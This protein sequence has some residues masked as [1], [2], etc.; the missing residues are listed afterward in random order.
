MARPLSPRPTDGGCPYPHRRP[1]SSGGIEE[2]EGK[3]PP[4]P[5]GRVTWQ[6]LRVR[7]WEQA[8]SLN[9]KF[10]PARERGFDSTQHPALPTR[11]GSERPTAE[12]T[13][14]RTPR[15]RTFWQSHPWFERAGTALNP[16]A[17]SLHRDAARGTLPSSPPRAAANPGHHNATRSLEDE[18]EM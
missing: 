14:P 5:S 10:Q 17:A 6:A 2:P 9:P 7:D 16:P 12:V 15:G 13:K 8:G 1:G 11:T 4:V 3:P 18:T